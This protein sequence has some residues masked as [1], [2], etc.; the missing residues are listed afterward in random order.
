MQLQS[1]IM[2][3]ITNMNNKL[4]WQSLLHH[5]SFGS[6]PCLAK[7]T[8]MA[9]YSHPT[10]FCPYYPTFDKFIWSH[11]TSMYD[12]MNRFDA[13]CYTFSFFFGWLFRSFFCFGT[14][15]KNHNGQYNHT[16]LNLWSSSDGSIVAL[17]CRAIS[18]SNFSMFTFT[19]FLHCGSSTFC[20]V[21]Y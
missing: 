21:R 10:S 4:N 3:T 15:E 7:C 1:Q 16:F 13:Y 14:I 8:F 18:L 20:F 11:Y 5:N 19:M 12:S 2:P 9:T 17:Y 6:Q